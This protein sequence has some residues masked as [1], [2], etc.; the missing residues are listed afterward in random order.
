MSKSKDTLEQV[1][2]IHALLE[3]L[4][5]VSILRYRLKRQLKA[6]RSIAL[7]DC[8]EE[9]KR[10]AWK[11]FG[12]EDHN[13]DLFQMTTSPAFS[14]N[15]LEGTTDSYDRFL[16]GEEFLQNELCVKL[17]AR[18]GELQSHIIREQEEL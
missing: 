4:R 9:R 5:E 6:L 2:D 13:K 16:S 18:L 8:P 15:W 1:D 14:P 7:A 17:S 3:E 11:E 10:L 12:Y